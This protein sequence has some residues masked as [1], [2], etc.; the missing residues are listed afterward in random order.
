MENNEDTSSGGKRKA[1]PKDYERNVVK[2]ARVK[3]EPYKNSKGVYIPGKA[4]V[5][6]CR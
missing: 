6:I 4:M 1:T 2:K 3:G 5:R